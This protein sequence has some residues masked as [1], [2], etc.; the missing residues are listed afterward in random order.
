M[1]FLSEDIFHY[2]DFFDATEYRTSH[3]NEIFCPPKVLAKYLANAKFSSFDFF[4]APKV[5][6][7]KDPL[8]FRIFS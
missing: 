6:S 1:H 2:C 7:D 5:A 3:S 4:P 8:Y